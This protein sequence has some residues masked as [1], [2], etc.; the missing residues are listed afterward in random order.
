MAWVGEGT[1]TGLREALTTWCGSQLSQRRCLA[2]VGA[3]IWQTPAHSYA[4]AVA[5]DPSVRTC[6]WCSSSRRGYVVRSMPVGYLV[7]VLAP[8]AA[9]ALSLWPQS[10]RRPRATPTFI[11]A[12]VANELPF[13]IVYWLVAD[14]VLAATEGDIDSPLGW[15]ALA[16][17]A[18]TAAG[19]AV[20]MGKRRGLDP[21]SIVRSTP[22][23]GRTVPVPPSGR[24]LVAMI[25]LASFC[26][27]S[28]RHCG[29]RHT[30][31]VASGTS[32]T[33][34]PVGRISST[35]IGTDPIPSDVQFSSTFTPAVSSAVVR[36][37]SLA[38]SSRGWSGPDGCASA[39]I[40][41]S[42]GPVGF[43]TICVDAKRAIAWIRA[44][45]A[46]YGVDSST[47]VVCGGSAGAYLTAM[48][49]L[50]ANDQA[51]QP[52]FERADTS[53][54]AAVGLYGFYGMPPDSEHS[55]AS[56]GACV[57]ADAPPFLVVHGA[58]DPMINAAHAREIRRVLPGRVEDAGSL[59]RDSGW[60]T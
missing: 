40:T 36:A 13:I 12:S 8:A 17:T 50:S 38:P 60:A 29:Y 35:S 7:S 10:T 54:S 21:C 20:V 30:R 1:E 5:T 6:R 44:H 55:P 18:C 33:G 22:D 51:F 48:C 46:N 4:M 37:A 34:P 52:S 49:A 57:R 42:D 39:P 24:I 56:P 3:S 58:H 26:V 47:L 28:S 9:T 27:P 53:V 59:R 45:A 19:S 11:F 32:R 14:T 43:R 16:I 41:A 2:L 25:V 31:S 15:V 23:W